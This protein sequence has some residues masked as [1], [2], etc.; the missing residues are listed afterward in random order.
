[1]KK[2]IGQGDSGKTHLAFGNKDGDKVPKDDARIEVAGTLDELVSLIGII[3]SFNRRKKLDTLLE[4]IQDHL[5][6]IQPLVAV[7]PGRETHPALPS[8]DS[9]LV[10]FLEKTITEYE[11]NLPPLQNF[12]YPGSTGSKLEAFLHLARANTRTVERILVAVSREHNTPLY[13][14]AYLNRLSDVFFT[15]SRWVNHKS[16]KKETK[17][18][19]KNKKGT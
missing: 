12:I 19:G 17:W 15:L 10:T 2:D 11:K 8:V 13:A 1:M 5:F 4:K 18:I 9:E 14:Q 6:R 3:R 16:K 7:I